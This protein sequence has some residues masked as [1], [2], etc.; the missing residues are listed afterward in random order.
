[1][2]VLDE[3]LAYGI[4]EAEQTQLYRVQQTL[5]LMAV[6]T[7]TVSM[8]Q[9]SINIDPAQLAAVFDLLEQQMVIKYKTI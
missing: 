9:Q 2:N 5:R 4:T 3:D 7:D 8:S 1:M 6:L